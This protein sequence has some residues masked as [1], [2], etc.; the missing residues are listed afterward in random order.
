METNLRLTPIIDCPAAVSPNPLKDFKTNPTRLLAKLAGGV[1]VA[2]PRS[3]FFPLNFIADT[4]LDYHSVS[5]F[6]GELPFP[7]HP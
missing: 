5:V 7:C 1:T 4:Y 2:S 3:S 6:P